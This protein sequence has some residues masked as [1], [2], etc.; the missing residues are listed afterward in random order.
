MPITVTE[1]KT[2]AELTT[3][4]WTA[5]R[6]RLV[7]PVTDASSRLK[8]IDKK[9]VNA[10]LTYESGEQITVKLDEP[11]T[12]EHDEA[13]EEEKAEERL[14]YEYEKIERKVAVAN[15]RFDAARTRMLT[16]LEGEGYGVDSFVLD[17][18]LEATAAHNVAGRVQEAVLSKEDLSMKDKV[19]RFNAMAL[20]ALSNHYGSQS[21]SNASNQ[22]KWHELAAWADFMQA[23]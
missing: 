1:T 19:E 22:L 4:Y 14:T 12:W 9:R 21:T 15:A 13:T 23:I 3:G 16:A 17:Q 10:V 5:S 18:M 6:Y 2:V 11:L 8:K 20:R 7:N